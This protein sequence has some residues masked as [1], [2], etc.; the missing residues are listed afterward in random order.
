MPS[1]QGDLS[2][3]KPDREIVLFVYVCVRVCVRARVCANIPYTG[4]KIP[5]IRTSPLRNKSR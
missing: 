3:I 4:M 1:K 2:G 5:A